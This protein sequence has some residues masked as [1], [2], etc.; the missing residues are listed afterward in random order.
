MFLDESVF[1][2]VFFCN[3]DESVPNLSFLIALL[4]IKNATPGPPISTHTA[5]RR[6]APHSRKS[7]THS[8]MR[9]TAMRSA[10]SCS[11]RAFHRMSSPVYSAPRLWYVT[12]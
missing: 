1:G 2:R 4:V 6:D 10:N 11:V 3:L 12:K 8:D 5:S 9:V 7:F